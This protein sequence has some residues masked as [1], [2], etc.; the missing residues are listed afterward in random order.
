MQIGAVSCNLVKLGTFCAD[1]CNVVPS[2]T[3]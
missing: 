3:V 2:G 1:L